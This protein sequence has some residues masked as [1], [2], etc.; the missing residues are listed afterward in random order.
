MRKAIAWE[1]GVDGLPKRLQPGQVDLEKRL[2]DWVEADIEIVA[3]DVLLI[4][5]QVVTPYGTKLDLLGIDA[6]GDL[7]IIEL[8]RDQTLRETVAQGIEYAA[9]SAKL[10][11]GDVVQYGALKYGDEDAFRQAFDERFGVPL[12]ETLNA[13]QRILLVAPEITDTTTSVIE[14]LA[15][16]YRMP[17][18]AVSFDVLALDGRQVIVRHVVR[19]EGHTPAPASGKRQPSRSR[20]EFIALAHENQVGE[21]FEQLLQL[22][23]TLPATKFFVQG[24]RFSA[25][26]P[27]GKVL[28][29]LNAFPTRE[30]YK[31]VLAVYVPPQN[32][33]RLYGKLQL[34]CETFV[35]GL[36]AVGKP[37]PAWS[38]WPGIGLT[39]FAQSEEFVRRVREF[40][41]T[42]AQIPAK[43]AT[44][45]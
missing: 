34:D 25:K 35:Q 3:D 31:H 38:G 39:T 4:G 37:L 42:T 8:K 10:G 14:Y 22:E 32:L 29:V 43:E 18:N 27:D 19:E 6:R 45:A 2:E 1:I 20:E 30:T 12:P 41:T 33:A 21:T 40:I 44:P 28:T 7:V 5:R 15:D 24:M 36:Q 26:A 16:T 11:Y 17:I 23:E 9:W 13:G